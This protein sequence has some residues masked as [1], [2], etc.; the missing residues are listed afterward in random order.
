MGSVRQF[1]WCKH[2][3]QSW[4]RDV[5]WLTT[6][7]SICQVG[8]AGPHTRLLYCFSVAQTRGRTSVSHATGPV[9]ASLLLVQGG[10][11]CFVEE[12]A[13]SPFWVSPGTNKLAPWRFLRAKGAWSGHLRPGLQNGLCL[14]YSR[15]LQHLLRGLPVSCQPRPLPPPVPHLGGYR[16][17]FSQGHGRTAPGS[18]YDAQ[19]SPPS[20]PSPSSRQA[21]PSR[22]KVLP[23]R[24]PLLVSPGA[25]AA[26]SQPSQLPPPALGG[27]P[28][29]VL[30]PWGRDLNSPCRHNGDSDGT[31]MG[32][33]G[34]LR[35]TKALTP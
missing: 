32:E 17:T 27:N 9:W 30:T 34:V 26:P 28:S 14:L 12:K 20:E 21:A 10:A 18:H 13:G 3:S 6:F 11:S 25:G 5:H 16:W 1:P 22:G 4:F 8:Q 19:G 35:G 29:S 24:I 31:C 7:L 33:W 15:V 2:S 23:R